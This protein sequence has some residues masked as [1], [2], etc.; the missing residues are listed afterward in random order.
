[1]VA[2]NRKYES[3]ISG[4]KLANGITDHSGPANPT[5]AW[6]GRRGYQFESTLGPAGLQYVRQ[7][8]YGPNTRQFISPDPLGLPNAT[9]PRGIE[10]GQVSGGDV[11]LFRYAGNNPVNRNDPS[12]AALE[13]VGQNLF[14]KV[15]SGETAWSIARK[16]TGHGA[17]YR[18]IFESPSGGFSHLHPGELLAVNPTEIGLIANHHWIAE[19]G[20]PQEPVVYVGTQGTQKIAFRQLSA[21]VLAGAKNYALAIARAI[22]WFRAAQAAGCPWAQHE[23]ANNNLV[24]EFGVNEA[25]LF[26]A[27]AEVSRGGEV[28]LREADLASLASKP[29][30]I[31]ATTVDF[32]LAVKAAREGNSSGEI[33]YGASTVGDIAGFFSPPIAIANAIGAIGRVIIDAYYGHAIAATNAQTAVRSCKFYHEQ[34]KAALQDAQGYRS[35]YKTVVH[36][37]RGSANR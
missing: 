2:I 7:R 31:A 22:K 26:E 16:L 13:Y 29:F 17:L 20:Q 12:G 8:W 33:S 25:A 28:A 27:F 24:T 21:T 18:K 30:G 34:Y 1:M 4:G 6:Q 11:N 15:H 14:W 10:S 5:V 35:D 19:P 37:I 36:V 3:H 32:A 9:V 23:A